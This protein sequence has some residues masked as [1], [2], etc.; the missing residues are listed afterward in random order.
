MPKKR[1]Y[2]PLLRVGQKPYLSSLLVQKENQTFEKHPE[3]DAQ[4]TR[5]AFF[6]CGKCNFE[7]AMDMDDMHDI[8]KK[9]CTIPLENTNRIK[10]TCLTCQKMKL[11]HLI[12]Q[13]EDLV[14][15]LSDWV[16]L[17]FMDFHVWSWQK[18]AD[19][20]MENNLL[21]QIQK[22]QDIS[23][24]LHYQKLLNGIS[25]LATKLEVFQ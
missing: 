22:E 15:L 24:N 10:M 5:L 12:K 3:K 11:D 6:Y 9:K 19:R 1:S 4:F 16:W 18:E 25:K 23:N 21:Y 8:V 13:K 2:K 17:D 14:D 20:D 7:Y